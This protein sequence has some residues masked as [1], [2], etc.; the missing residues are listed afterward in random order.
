MFKKIM[1]DREKI[2]AVTGLTNSEL[3][4]F[5]FRNKINAILGDIFELVEN[6]YKIPA[7][8]WQ[9][10]K[11]KNWRPFIEEL[12][13]P[14][15]RAI[16][17]SCPVDRCKLVSMNTQTHRKIDTKALFEW[18]FEYRSAVVSD[19]EIPDLYKL[20]QKKM[21]AELWEIIYTFRVNIDKKSNHIGRTKYPEAQNNL[22][23]EIYRAAFNDMSYGKLAPAA[24]KRCY[25]AGKEY[26][27][28]YLPMA[29]LE[30]NNSKNL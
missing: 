18:W 12:T 9:H 6:K 15:Q 22:P 27:E 23:K 10:R 25:F 8:F 26:I 21:H 13:T 4:D 24:F 5:I 14:T 1:T 29:I 20:A 2:E 3:I 19:E 17:D 28:K 16:I 11:E 30:A 7:L